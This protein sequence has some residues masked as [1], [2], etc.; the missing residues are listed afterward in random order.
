MHKKNVYSSMNS[1]KTINYVATNQITSVPLLYSST[2]P[3]LQMKLLTWLLTLYLGVL[4]FMLYINRIKQYVLNLLSFIRYLL[5]SF[6]MI[7]K[8]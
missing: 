7:M 1:N 4:V 3:P 2:F 5:D 6:M 8:L